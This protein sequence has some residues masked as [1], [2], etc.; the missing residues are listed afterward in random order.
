M[1]RRRAYSPPRVQPNLTP[2]VD[3]VF[4]LVV[5]FMLI[6]QLSKEEVIDMTLPRL[7]EPATEPIAAEGRVIVNVVPREL[8]GES[9]GFGGDYRVST[10]SFTNTG[11]GVNALTGVLR[12]ARM[13]DSGVR[14]IVRASRTERYDR[15]HPVLQAV[16]RAGIARVDLVALPEEPAR[17]GGAASPATLGSERG[18]G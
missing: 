17:D 7:R 8:T 11:E 12:E 15:V 16:T 9:G 1:K 14:V 4:M 2:L 3:V 18:R 5:F 13:R 10:L 6:T